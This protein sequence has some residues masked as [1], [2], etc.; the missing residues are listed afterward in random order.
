MPRQWVQSIDTGDER[1]FRGAVRKKKKAR[2][3][4]G[5]GNLSGHSGRTPNRCSLSTAR[6]RRGCGGSDDLNDR[7][8]NQ[9][10]GGGQIVRQDRL[11]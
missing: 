9:C 8:R 1:A 7:C 10:E 4:P 11:G 6:L 3:E 2:R 5:L